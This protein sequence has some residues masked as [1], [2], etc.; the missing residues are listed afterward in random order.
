MA[1][2]LRDKLRWCEFFLWQP[3]PLIE[4]LESV[5]GDHNSLD[6]RLEAAQADTE[7]FSFPPLKGALLHELVKYFDN[8]E[9]GYIN[10]A[11][12][13]SSRKNRQRKDTVVKTS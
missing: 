3:D 2:F 10:I 1:V 9:L 11:G 4:A 7:V 13:L 8:C 6:G 12:V 5:V